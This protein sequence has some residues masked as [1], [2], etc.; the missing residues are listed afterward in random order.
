MIM[1]IRRNVWVEALFRH[2][3]I[4]G[5]NIAVLRYTGAPIMALQACP[6]AGKTRLVTPQ[7]N[8][9]HSAEMSFL[10]WVGSLPG[11]VPPITVLTTNSDKTS[12]M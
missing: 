5:K 1:E 10:N 3:S 8:S 9:A 7:N 11:E 12:F 6:V 2:I 4:A